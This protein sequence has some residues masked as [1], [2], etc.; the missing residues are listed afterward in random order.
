M[1]VDP[2]RV[3]VGI[4][5][6]NEAA[7][8]EACV[9]SLMVPEAEMARVRFVIADGGSHDRSRPIAARIAERWPQVSVILLMILA[10]VIV[11][12]MLTARVRRAII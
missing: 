10:T 3:I 7:H 11:S 12:E 6:L 4:P 9:A 8:L 5:V 1:A 2:E